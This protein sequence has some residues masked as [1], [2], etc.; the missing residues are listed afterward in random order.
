MSR[1]SRILTTGLSVIKTFGT[2]VLGEV[3]FPHAHSDRHPDRP[4]AARRNARGGRGGENGESGLCSNQHY[5][6]E[7]S[8]ETP[9]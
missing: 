5:A 4:H 7:F 6:V 3:K 1:S 2:V 9:V 8:Y